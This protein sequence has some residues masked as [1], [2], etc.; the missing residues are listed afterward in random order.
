M[1][2]LVTGGA[3]F[4]G[5]HV[6][7]A[8]VAEGHDV[9]V[10]DDLSTGRRDNV[11]PRAEFVQMDIRDETL[12]EVFGKRSFDVVNHLAAQ[13]QVSYSVREPR[14]DMDINVRGTMN[15]L[16]AARTSGVQR[17]IFASS[18]GTV[19]GHQN[20]ESCD[21]DQPKHPLSP[22]GAA[23]L[24]IEH[25]LYAY[26]ACYGMKSLALRY[27]N[28]YGPRQNPHGEAGVV[29]I[30]LRKMLSGQQPIIN[31]SGTQTRDYIYIDDVVRANIRAL[32]SDYTGAVNV[33]TDRETSVL[34]IV[35]ALEASTQLPC[36]RVHR[37]ALP[38]EP[39]R[40]RYNNARARRELGWHPQVTLNEGIERT[41]AWER[42][43]GK[44][45][46]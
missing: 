14:H 42:E 7:D 20:V 5:S 3:G 27:G 24:S 4:I 8:Y 6:V 38:G 1:K 44:S 30:F 46:Q 36:A 31:G 40:G 18:A 43:R 33:T 34:E 28:V 16:E 23:K 41:V 37:P 10:L 12:S 11:H 19:Y 22:Y 29:A 35:D 21:E 2:I 45:T 13:M 17:I 15:I 9:T 26:A 39:M 25:Y 32:H